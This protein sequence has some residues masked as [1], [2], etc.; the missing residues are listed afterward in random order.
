[1]PKPGEHIKQA[2]ERTVGSVSSGM[3][4]AHARHGRSIGRGR[5]THHRNSMSCSI[6]VIYFDI[7]A[8]WCMSEHIYT[9][10]DLLLMYTPFVAE[11]RLPSQIQ[12]RLHH[13]LQ[14]TRATPKLNIS[15]TH[16][17]TSNPKTNRHG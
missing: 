12:A 4:I 9:S 5:Y 3:I 17:H 7:Y 13:P 10:E 16:I 1:M 11:A 14:P 15:R 2:T 8:R 6:E